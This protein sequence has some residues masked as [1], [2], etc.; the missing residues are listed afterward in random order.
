M[1][2][3]VAFVVAI[4]LTGVVYW[5]LASLIS[6][7]DEEVAYGA[8]LSSARNE[9]PLPAPSNDVNKVVRP[10]PNRPI[11]EE[12]YYAPMIMV[13]LYWRSDF[14]SFEPLP[15]PEELKL[16]TNRPAP[17]PAPGDYQLREK[18]RRS[19]SL[20]CRPRSSPAV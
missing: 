17:A 3:A 15:L 12:Q 7:A 10:A 14:Q 9:S 19:A 5:T 1:R 11:W 6:A 8:W 18:T 13:P 20:G 4:L 16:P 2:K